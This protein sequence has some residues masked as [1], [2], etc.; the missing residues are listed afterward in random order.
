MKKTNRRYLDLR[1]GWVVFSPVFG[2]SNTLML[3]YIT[4]VSDLFPLWLFIV[5]SLPIVII[6]LIVIGDLFR[7]K[8]LDTDL[9]LSFQR[10]TLHGHT[11]YLMMKMQHDIATKL[12]LNVSEKFKTQMQYMKDIGE[13]KFKK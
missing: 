6:T 13:N 9:D 1:N 12:N 5:V 4:F 8:Q 7:K 3:A 10:A 2:L 11:L